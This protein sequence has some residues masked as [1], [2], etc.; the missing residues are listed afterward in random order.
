M[1]IKFAEVLVSAR[2]WYERNA[3]N[4][5]KY[6]LVFADFGTWSHLFRYLAYTGKPSP[7]CG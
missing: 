4:I 6:L 1:L 7:Q 5:A 2:E 3:E